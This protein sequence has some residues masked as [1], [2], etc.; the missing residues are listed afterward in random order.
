[1]CLQF[2]SMCFVHIEDRAHWRH[3]GGGGEVPN[4]FIVQCVIM[5]PNAFQCVF[6]CIFLQCVS[7]C[8]QCFFNVFFAHWNTLKHIVV[9][10]AQLHKN[11]PDCNV[12]QCVIMCLQCALKTHSMCF[13][14]SPIFFQCVSWALGYWR[15]LNVQKTHWKKIGGTLRPI[16]C[17]SN[18]SPRWGGWSLPIAW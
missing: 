2:F 15:I 1:M 3:I 17:V 6:Q 7:M 14:V 5:C 13:N 12:F 9:I 8:L 18:R 10:V 11:V 4:V 16:Q